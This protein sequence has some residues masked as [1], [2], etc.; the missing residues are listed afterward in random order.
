[1]LCRILS[2]EAQHT[3]PWNCPGGCH[4]QWCKYPSLLSWFCSSY[5]HD[6]SSLSG[7]HCRCLWELEGPCFWCYWSSPVNI[8]RH[9]HH[10]P[11]CCIVLWRCSRC[12]ISHDLWIQIC[13]LVPCKCKYDDFIMFSKYHNAF[14]GQIA[15]DQQTRRITRVLWNVWHGCLLPVFRSG[16]IS[17]HDQ[18][19]W[20]TLPEGGDTG[21]WLVNVPGAVVVFRPPTRVGPGLPVTSVT[22]DILDRAVA[23]GQSAWPRVLLDCYWG[24]EIIFLCGIV[25]RWFSEAEAGV[26][27]VRGLGAWSPGQW[28]VLSSAL[29]S[30]R[31][32][33]GH[34]VTWRGEV[35]A[36]P[37]LSVVTP[38]WSLIPHGDLWCLHLPRLPDSGIELSA[39][40]GHRPDVT[41]G[42]WPPET[43]GAISGARSAAGHL[44][45][46]L[47][48]GARAPEMFL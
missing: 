12:D 16:L 33:D 17:I 41:D 7:A 32:S 38:L 28:A 24:S 3:P 27:A 44:A 10:D 4:G 34:W 2:D 23:A 37:V 8:L 36:P 9:W 25:I 45:A 39:G 19:M 46:G 40:V 30:P 13:I 20:L 11:E 15:S 29:L 47:G 18:V 31:R 21:C 5:F 1:M 26:V 42:S 35:G 6:Y 22:G 48:Q 43:P 14:Y